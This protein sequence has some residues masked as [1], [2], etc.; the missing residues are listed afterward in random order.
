MDA[1]TSSQKVYI[2]LW[3]GGVYSEL[4]RRALIGPQIDH[5]QAVA[6]VLWLLANIRRDLGSFAPAKLPEVVDAPALHLMANSETSRSGTATTA[7]TIATADR[8]TTEIDHYR[9]QKSFKK[10]QLAA[11]VLSRAHA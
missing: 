3:L 1:K 8:R 11:P 7:T 5:R 10:G 2:M 6:H 4:Q 9:S